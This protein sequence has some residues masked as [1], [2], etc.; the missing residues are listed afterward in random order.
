MKVVDTRSNVPMSMRLFVMIYGL[1]FD[2]FLGFKD[3]R[4]NSLTTVGDLD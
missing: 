4:V 1:G 3:N 2:Q